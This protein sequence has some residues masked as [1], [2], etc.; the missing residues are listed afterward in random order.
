MVPVGARA[1]EAVGRWTALRPQ[2][3]PSRY[4]FPS[5][6]GQHLSRVRLFQ[7]VKALAGRAGLD[8][9]APADQPLT[10]GFELH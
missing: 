10:I 6:K 8:P 5:A 3:P 7:L 4:L 9:A 1:L 2:E